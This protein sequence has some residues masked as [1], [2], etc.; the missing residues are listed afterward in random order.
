MSAT[1]FHT[2]TEQRAISS[3]KGLNILDF[4]VHYLGIGTR[5]FVRQSV[6]KVPL[7]FSLLRHQ[8]W[9]ANRTRVN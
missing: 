6:R 3:L 7:T 9:V 5:N 1:K 4:Y 2:H 8:M